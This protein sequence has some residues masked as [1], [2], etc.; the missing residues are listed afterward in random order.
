[1]SGDVSLSVVVKA[2]ASDEWLAYLRAVV[3]KFGEVVVVVTDPLLRTIVAGW[4]AEDGAKIVVVD[5]TP[6]RR[7]GL[8]F[9]D[10]AGSY[11]AGEPLAG[12][13]YEGPY[14]GRPVVADW[15]AVRNLGWS[16]CSLGWRAVL[17][18]DERVRGLEDVGDVCRSAEE[19]GGQVVYAPRTSSRGRRTWC[20]VAVQ[21]VPELWWEGLVRERVGDGTARP[22]LVDVVSVDGLKSSRDLADEWKTLYRGARRRGWDVAP[23]TLVDMV[24]LAPSAGVGQLVPALV[25]RHLEDSLDVEER[26]WACSLAG[27][28]AEEDGFLEEASGWYERSV[29]E[30]PGLKSFL[31]LS[32]VRFKLGD[33]AGCLEAFRRAVEV[34]SKVQWLDDGAEDLLSSLLL[35]NVSIADLGYVDEAKVNGETLVRCFSDVPEVGDLCRKVVP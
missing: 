7:P 34:R 33:S 28:R 18:S 11:Q 24:R 15:S 29:A 2:G 25:R 26:A 23:H 4:K 8:Y 3:P 20:P 35:A 10:V 5:A 30:D 12:E 32:R 19:A 9:P 27:E 21:N 1:M 6:E 13:A 31:R 17:S 22:V 16:R 14:T